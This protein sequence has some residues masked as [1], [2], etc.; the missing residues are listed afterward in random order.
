MQKDDNNKKYYQGLGRRK[1]A[2][3]RVRLYPH[4]KGGFVINEKTPEQFFRYF[5][6]EQQ[7]KAPLKKVKE[8]QKVDISVKV[9]GGGKRGQAEA[10]QLGIARALVAM[11]Q[12]YK[13]ELRKHGFLTR[14]SRKKERKKPGLKRARRAPQWRK[15]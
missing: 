7:V 5:E 10:I 14:D 9:I 8:I 2:V 1:T 3:A 4:G 11:N 6:F 12:E 15:R 13:M